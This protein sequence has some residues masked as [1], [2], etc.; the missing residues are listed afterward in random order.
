MLSGRPR[1]CKARVSTPAA[2]RDS[3]AVPGLAL[4][5]HPATNEAVKSFKAGKV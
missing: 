1:N 3:S 5:S 4:L 2:G